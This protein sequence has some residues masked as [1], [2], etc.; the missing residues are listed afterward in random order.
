MFLV[1]DPEW[2][3]DFRNDTLTPFFKIFP[4]FVSDYFF[5]TIIGIGYWLRPQIPLFIHL[6]FLVPFSSLVNY[7]LKAIFSIPRPPS[8]LHLISVQNSWGFPSG[9]A[10]VAAIFW[11]CIF[12]SSHSRFLRMFCAGMIITIMASRVYLG[13]HSLYDVGGGLLFGILMII[14]WNNSYVKHVTLKWFQGNRKSLYLL[15]VATL[16]LYSIMSHNT[17]WPS[18]L[19][20]SVGALLGY[21]WCLPYLQAQSPVF[22]NFSFRNLLIIVLSLAIL[23]IFAKNMPLIKENVLTFYSSII[24]KYAVLAIMIYLFLPKWQRKI[25]GTKPLISNQHSK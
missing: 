4:F 18:G 12:L 16:F 1:S 14:L 15:I 11:G 7:T 13:V 23:I 9:D 21:S 5:M 20:A 25:S 17:V 22:Q 8:S 19:L 3:L 10:Q 6:G 2:I 24:F